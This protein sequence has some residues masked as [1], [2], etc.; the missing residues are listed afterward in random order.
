[1][2]ARSSCLREVCTPHAHPGPIFYVKLDA[3]WDLEWGGGQGTQG[4][5][6]DLACWLCQEGE[7]WFGR[8]MSL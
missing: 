2:S 5:G 3:H 8:S 1:M 4:R 6:V 7:A